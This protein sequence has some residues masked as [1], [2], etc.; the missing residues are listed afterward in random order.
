MIDVPADGDPVDVL[1][2]KQ[3]IVFG[4]GSLV[5]SDPKSIVTCLPVTSATTPC[6]ECSETP[7][8][9]RREPLR[10]FYQA[11]CLKPYLRNF[12]CCQTETSELILHHI[13]SHHITSHQNQFNIILRLVLS[14]R[15]D[16]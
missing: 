14:A 2:A 8:K 6:V 1:R 10:S 12:L 9:S 13:Q 16:R 11:P 15:L 5:I 3:A 7:M 4:V